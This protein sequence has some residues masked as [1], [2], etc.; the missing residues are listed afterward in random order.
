[1]R[2]DQSQSLA[3]VVNEAV[4]NIRDAEARSVAHSLIQD[5]VGRDHRVLNLPSFHSALV[6]A[7][8]DAR[9]KGQDDCGV[10]TL[11]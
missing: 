11:S 4:Q 6:Q 9:L 5:Y 1:M 3:G 2:S 8:K 10:Q 7:L